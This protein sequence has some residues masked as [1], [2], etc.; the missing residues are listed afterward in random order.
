MKRAAAAQATKVS[1]ML[2]KGAFPICRILKDFQWTLATVARSNTS[3]RLCNFHTWALARSR[4][5]SLE[6]STP[7]ES[8]T[9][10]FLDM[11]KDSRAEKVNSDDGSLC[12][13]VREEEVARL[14]E[15]ARE[16]QRAK[17]VQWMQTQGSLC[18][19]HAGNLRNLSLL[20]FA[21]SWMKSWSEI[22]W[23]FAMSW[24]LS[25]SNSSKEYM[26]EADCW[27]A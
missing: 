2:V 16:F 6:R 23:S 8:V 12:H 21:N 27:V 7:G 19:D 26:P 3:L 18:V 25:T 10:V 5:G 11:L 17:F 13:C 24:R 20:R 4:G 9:S 15:L 22:A 14:H 1:Q